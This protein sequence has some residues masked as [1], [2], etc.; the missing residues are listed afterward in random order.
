MKKFF[1]PLL[2]A[3]A[4][5]ASYAPA[6][7]DGFVW[8]D[9]ALILR[10]P[11]IRSW[12]LIPEGFQ[13]F[14]FTDATASDFYRPLQRL[15]Y[16]LEY[17]AFG[18]QAAPYHVTS[19]LC[20][21]AA[22]MALL[23]AANELLKA[24]GVEEG[25]RRP[26]AFGATLIWAIHPVQSAAVIYISGRADPLAGAF[27]FAGLY[28]GL[29]CAQLEGRRRWLFASGAGVLFLLSALSKELGLLFPLL[30]CAVLVMQRKPKLLMLAVAV[31]VAVGL[32]YASLRLPAEHISPPIART[33]MPLLVRPVVAARAVAEYAVLIVFPR[34]LHMDRDVETHPT[35]LSDASITSAAWRELQ[36]LLGILVIATWVWWLIRARTRDPAVFGCLA[37]AGIAYLPISG[38]VELNAT[39]AEHWIYLPTAFLF[40]A[41]STAVARLTRSSKQPQLLLT[42]ALVVVIPLWSLFLAGR[43]FVRTSDWKD[44]RTFLERT[45]ADGG[46]SARMRI[47]LAG[48][49]LN[50]G[51]FENAKKDLREALG[52]APEQPLAVINLA[53]V[54]IKENDFNA[55]HQLLARAVAM[56]LVSAEAHELTAVLLNKEK[57]QVDL[58]R[59]RLAARTGP[60]N[61]AIEKRYI[62][63][64]AESGHSER[65]V[66]ELQSCLKMQWYRAESWQLLSELLAGAGR[67]NGAAQ[68]CAQ[69][70][71]FDVHL[72]ER[73]K[74][75]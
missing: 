16:T 66:E 33:P 52:K 50:E 30:W 40:L 36:T 54:A 69:A 44:Q 75:L 55:A 35:G 34:N 47:N 8:D 48:V 1:L 26:A 6:I 71:A 17:W 4:V 15:T 41:L 60:P 11:L 22:A 24:F 28:C 61:W 32:I 25:I 23:A 49:E 9:T 31:S 19:I 56:P 38:L 29:R 46:D 65:A 74:V 63:V 18:A 53:T 12:R 72:E 37:L 42:R 20:H 64:L 39:I 70:R 68:A 7:R 3:L 27:G 57:G 21:I 5:F 13:H 58:L 43:T 45:I 2:I 73:R 67:S 62:K 51:R 10:D 59:L 14:L